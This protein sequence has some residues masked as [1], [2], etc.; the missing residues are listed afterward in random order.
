MHSKIIL[1]SIVIVTAAMAAF[2]MTI[3]INATNATRE[4]TA[5]KVV[6]AGGGNTTI[7]F[8]RFLPKDVQIN[9]GESVVWY[10]PTEVSEP[11]TVT[12]VMDSK[13]MTDIIAPFA[14]S[15]STEFIPLP[16]DANSEVVAIP[17]SNGTN[18]T[19]VIAALD[20]RGFYPV[21][22][23]ST[24]NVTYLNSNA[25]YVIDGTEKY[26]NSGVI[27]P[28]GQIP[29]G[30]PPITTFTAT[31]EKTGNYDYICIFHPWMTGRIIVK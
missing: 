30:I 9:A 8:S 19:N 24:N 22:I 2:V 20:A 7:S 4:E 1:A 6:Q 23:N 31:F 17:N 28:V 11:H 25:L 13:Y 16:T 15:D 14:V 18:R 5:S 27:L 29:P 12:F 3:H 21:V 26:V 10:N